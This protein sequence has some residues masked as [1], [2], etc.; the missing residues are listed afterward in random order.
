MIG[1]QSSCTLHFVLRP[2][3][4]SVC[5]HRA[6]PQP[7]LSTSHAKNA[8]MIVNCRPLLRRSFRAQ[9]RPWSLDLTS[10]ALAGD[11]TQKHCNVGILRHMLSSGSIG[12]VLPD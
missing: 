1:L 12:L 7:S 8:P 11:T 2:L 5:S 9:S 3:Q 6:V 4:A 10:Q